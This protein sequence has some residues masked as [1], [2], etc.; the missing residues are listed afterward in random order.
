MALRQ[1]LL[2]LR[3]LHVANQQLQPRI[4]G[5]VA[6]AIRRQQSIVTVHQDSHILH[7]HNGNDVPGLGRHVGLKL[8]IIRVIETCD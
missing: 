4:C 5:T 6:Q 1:R 3:L 2:R 8:P 7:H